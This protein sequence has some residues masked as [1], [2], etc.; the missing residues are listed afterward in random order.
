ME[1]DSSRLL[2]VEGEGKNY[3]DVFKYG[4]NILGQS[5]SI[6]WFYFSLEFNAEMIAKY[7]PDYYSLK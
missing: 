5:A 6:T 2:A 4:G 3:T 7:N 1:I